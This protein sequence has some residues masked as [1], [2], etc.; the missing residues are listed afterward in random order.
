MNNTEIRNR[1]IIQSSLGNYLE[2]TEDNVY[3]ADVFNFSLLSIFVLDTL[4]TSLMVLTFKCS[5]FRE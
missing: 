5:L 4:F 3:T 1:S 2:L